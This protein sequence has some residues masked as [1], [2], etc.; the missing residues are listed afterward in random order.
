MA[1]ILTA[2]FG[3]FS[4]HRGPTFTGSVSLGL[5]GWGMTK[6]PKDDQYSEEETKR[7]AEEALRGAFKTPPISDKK[8][9]R[10]PKPPPK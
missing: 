7:R 2:H 3:R 10:D 1:A 6:N 9:S 5:K 8:G 4:M